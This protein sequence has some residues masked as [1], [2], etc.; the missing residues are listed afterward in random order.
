MR[1]AHTHSLEHLT[2]EIMYRSANPSAIISSRLSTYLKRPC[3]SASNPCPLA[4]ELETVH[5]RRTY[6]YL[7]TF[8]HQLIPDPATLT[9]A[10]PQRSIISPS[11]SSA[12]SATNEDED[13]Q[14]IIR[15][16]QLSPS[17]EV[18]LATMEF[19]EPAMED[20]AS[21][22]PPTPS[23]NFSGRL[24]KSVAGERAMRGQ[25]PPLEKDEKEFTLTARGMQRRRLGRK[26]TADV[27]AEKI[28]PSEASRE[29]DMDGDLFGDRHQGHQIPAASSPAM[30]PASLHIATGGCGQSVL[31]KRNWGDVSDMWREGALGDVHM[32]GVDGEGWDSRSPEMV[33]LDELD[34]LLYGF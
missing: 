14:D 32:A 17:P 20:D 9:A 26:D 3:W 12:E 19:D 7:T 4:K 25:S 29:R 1:H 18:D 31:G 11:L 21:V 16:R 34:G 8:P 15:R 13:A 6:F 27:Q 33:D 24:V 10:F 2:D 5:P 28:E 22:A 23:G 30:K